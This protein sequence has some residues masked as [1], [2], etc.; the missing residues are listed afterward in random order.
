ME[1]LQKIL[2]RAGLASRREAERWILEGRVTVNGTVIKKLG[3]RADASRDKIKVDGKLIP[4]PSHL[5]FLFHKPTGLITSMRD[6]QGRP[7]LGEWLEPLRTRGRLFPVGRLDFNSS[8]LLLLTND[9]ELSQRVTHPRYEVKKGYRVKIS[10]RPSERELDRLRRGI[11]LEDER[12]APARVRVLQLLRKKAWLEVEIHEGRYREVRRMFEAL[13][14]FVEKLIRVRLG[15]VRLGS[16][17]PGEARPLSREEITA[18][19][20]AVGM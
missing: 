10:A 9:G 6:L 16:L 20:K 3:S 17:G 8:G 4:A 7:D 1:R 5:Y 15:P 11:R 18:L 2:A 19:K 13:G 12:T 14:Y